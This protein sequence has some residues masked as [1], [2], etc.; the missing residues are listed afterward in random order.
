VE[1]EK[2][3]T[4]ALAGRTA[5]VTGAAVRVGAEIARRLARAGARVA[6]HFNT[7]GDAAE[8]LVREIREAGGDARPFQANLARTDEIESL[9][10]QLDA[11]HI[12]PD[13]LVNSAACF[14]PSPTDRPD[15]DGWRRTLDINL[16]APYLLAMLAAPKMP[17][18][19]GDIVNIA[20]VWGLRP[21][22]SHMAYSTSKAGLIML[23]RALARAFAP[24]IRVNAIAPGPVLLPET[25]S[26]RERERALARTL[27]MREGRAADVAE[28]VHFLV[29]ATDYATGSVLTIDGGRSAV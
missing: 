12:L 1:A 22:G 15:L 17:A 28:A 18:H 27:L 25:M 23:T 6:I 10:Q 20:D 8:R 4:R 29:A 11:D 5:L 7:S 14:D 26:D 2:S 3:S 9:F 13:I 19:G 21:L 24:R 16:T